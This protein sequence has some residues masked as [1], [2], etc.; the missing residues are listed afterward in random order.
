MIFK[1]TVSSKAH[2]EYGSATI[3]FP[4]PDSE[5]ERTIGSLEAMGLASPAVQDCYRIGWMLLHG[6]GTDQDEAAALPWLEKAGRGNSCAK[7]HLGKLLLCG[8][9]LPKDT[10]RAVDLL[11]QCA[12]SGD[13]FAQYTLGKA[14]LLGKDIPQDQEQAVHWLTLTA[15]QGA[16]YFLNRFYGSVFSSAVSLLYHMG[17]IFQNQNQQPAAGGGSWWK[18]SSGGGSGRRRSPWATSRMTTRR[19]SGCCDAVSPHPL[20]ERRNSSVAFL[21]CAKPPKK[22]P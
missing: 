19:N 17:R 22:N 14:Y 11:T 15:E 10:E 12:E 3:P 5:Y 18:A 21:L 1:A 8:Q 7:Y 9:S 13:Q 2:P 6:V 20:A 4:I 16:Q